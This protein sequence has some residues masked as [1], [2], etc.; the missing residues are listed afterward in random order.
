MKNSDMI[1]EMLGAVFQSGDICRSIYAGLRINS[2]R[3]LILHDIIVNHDRMGRDEMRCK[4]YRYGSM[5][6]E[7]EHLARH[8]FLCLVRLADA[9]QNTQEQ[10]QAGRN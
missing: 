4:A 9:K 2:E 1:N 10:V 7:E 3:L 5:I 6:S 8:I